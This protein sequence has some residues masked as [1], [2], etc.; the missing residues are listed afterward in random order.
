MMGFTV[1][2][3]IRH[4]IKK[5][6]LLQHVINGGKF[7]VIEQNENKPLTIEVTINNDGSVTYLA[8]DKNSPSGV[9][10]YQDSCVQNFIDDYLSQCDYVAVHWTVNA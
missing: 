3:T 5:S 7:Q 9:Y 4:S 6:D 8:Y 10:K 1:D 2:Y